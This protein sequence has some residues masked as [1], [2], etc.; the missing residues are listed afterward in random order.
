[1]SISGP[2]SAFDSETFG[3]DASFHLDQPIGSMT[4]SPSGRDVALAS[5]EGLH[6]IDLDSPYS[7]PRHLPH[8]TPWEVADV[9]WS[10]F[11]SRDYWVVST[12]NQKALVWNLDAKYWQDSVQHI[13]HG[14]RRAITD[15]N[16]S[17]HNPDVLATCAV[18]SF[19][20]SWD[21]RAP[22]RPAI[23]FSD[24]FAAATQV[25]W[26]RQDEYV[27]AS[28]HDK[29][30]R[31]WDTRK[32]A[33]PVRTV[34][35]HS[36]RIY[37]LDWN[38]FERNKIV[39]C[40][41]D[42]T[43]KFWN[44]DNAEDVPDR[45][46]ET[47][48][49]VWRARHTPFGWGLMAMAQ[50]G[51]SSLHLYD[52]RP[53]DVPL[54]DGRARSVATFS[55]HNGQ[56]K[57][58]L[59]RARGGFQDDI[60]QREFQLVSWGTDKELRLHRVT[61]EDLERVGYEKGVSK[62][63][64]LNFT[65]RGARYV[66]FRDLPDEA[67][68]P[69]VTPRGESSTS[70]NAVSAFRKRNST[71]VGMNKVAVSQIKG[72][73][74]SQQRSSRIAMH[75]KTKATGEIDPIAWLKNVKI[76]SWDPD[77]LA[78]E[79]R[80]VGEKFRRVR[81]EAVDI[82]HRKLVM[83]LQAPW[84]DHQGAVYLRVDIRFP[85]SYP[86]H[87]QAIITLQKTSALADEMHDNLSA[88]LREIA[89][90]HMAQQ[91]GC[92]EATLRYLLREQSLEQVIA[93]A[94]GDSLNESKVLGPAVGDEDSSDSEDDQI[95][96]LGAAVASAADIRVPLAKG[97]GAVWSE[98]GKLVCFFPPKP[99]EPASVL[100]GLSSHGLARADTRR[101]FEG[102]GKLH[103]DSPMRRSA[104]RAKTADEDFSGSESSA[105]LSSSSESS[106]SSSASEADLPMS[107]APY[108]KRLNKFPQRTRSIDFS[109]RSTTLAGARPMTTDEP[110]QTIV[111]IMTL[112]DL[113]Q[114]SRSLAEKYMVMG[115][116]PVLCKHNAT[117]AKNAGRTDL[118]V[119]WDLAS[120]ILEDE[121]PVEA[122]ELAVAGNSSIVLVACQAVSKPHRKDSDLALRSKRNKKYD[123][124]PVRWGGS[125]L[126]STY[127]IP[128]MFDYFE[129]VA[130]VQMLA[131]LS[132]AFAQP[133]STPESVS[134]PP[135]AQPEYF[136]SKSVAEAFFIA[137]RPL[138]QW[139]TASAEPHPS[140]ERLASSFENQGDLRSRRGTAMSLDPNAASFR[141]GSELRRTY[142]ST[143]GELERHSIDA[144]LSTSPEGA[145]SMH[146]GI[147]S[148]A[149]Q[150]SLSA[151]TQSFSHSPPTQ[152]SSG[153]NAA[154]SLKKYSPS[155]SL[156]PG[157]ISWTSGHGTRASR[158]SMHY[159]ES[160]SQDKEVSLRSSASMANIRSLRRVDIPLLKLVAAM[161][162][163]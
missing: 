131:M 26:S 101:L 2:S 81:F 138:A 129:R 23:S 90:V 137:A 24:W 150:A 83:S 37:G 41:L 119:V 72:W 159:S 6:I 29:F 14:H 44:C 28:S 116:A 163:R 122:L 19:V 98:T 58:F 100:T 77:A 99:K 133:K 36:T 57:E 102:F 104:D 153:S 52:R 132:C 149:A 51:S 148:S 7:P 88:E 35:A 127:L 146:R 8:R 115:H 50:R 93:Y 141:P 94:R 139:P 59:W 123:R 79:I 11:A 27:L 74:S 144:S 91:R 16:F 80:H 61:P 1:M 49:P 87:A 120:M 162:G 114:A 71:T 46:I 145:R 47:P 4:I 157:W 32:G 151:L 22:G 42:R 63:Q 10:P 34:E 160:S 54:E 76:A 110:K 121:V 75:G 111:S 13:L 105:S 154:S 17:A 140:I 125:P 142:S 126:A 86:R 9:Q 18:D 20:H 155:G 135:K 136:P 128:A 82:K 73:M 124:K 107:Y 96:G 95:A 48:Y 68:S 108:H 84:S 78:E 67:I 33:I 38:R 62:S 21:L 130:D 143:A 112:D 152:P 69:A 118:S 147:M 64:N 40:S 117:I 89:A 103:V 31:I 53:I 56:I 25:K 97:C 106:S 113:N 43:I 109:N 60:D 65:R 15:I 3:Q 55:G 161:S 5:K 156:T 12:S 45:V 134:L 158:A 39:T 66:T 30:L 70:H 85:Q 92:L